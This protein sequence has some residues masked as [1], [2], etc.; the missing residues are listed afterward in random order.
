MAGTVL[1]MALPVL[2]PMAHASAA[3]LRFACVGPLDVG[4]GGTVTGTVPGALLLSS[5]TWD[6]DNATVQGAV[7]DR[8]RYHRHRLT[9]SGAST[10][11]GNSG[12]V[13]LTNNVVTGTLTFSDNSGGSPE[14][15]AIAVQSNIV[16]GSLNCVGNTPA[17]SNYTNPNEV[18]GA[19]TGQC[20]G[21]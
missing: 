13:D 11:I 3:P 17:P 19:R 8:P 20:V 18:T 2:S 12:G 6:V 4:G 1:A 9:S 14:G 5:G 21:L 15:P 7:V 16:G 10:L